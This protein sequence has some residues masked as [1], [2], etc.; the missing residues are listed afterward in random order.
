MNK[1]DMN[2]LNVEIA[3]IKRRDKEVKILTDIAY[4]K[5]Y[6]ENLIA[7]KNLNDATNLGALLNEEE[8]N[9]EDNL[10]LLKQNVYKSLEKLGSS[11]NASVKIYDQIFQQYE[12]DLT[13]FQFLITHNKELHAEL[14]STFINPTSNNLIS[15]LNKYVQTDNTPIKTVGRRPVLKLEAG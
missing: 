11:Y 3:N 6:G 8:R 7:T 14:K 9:D 12:G 10:I 4:I 13:P 15:L 1:I 5:E 2:L